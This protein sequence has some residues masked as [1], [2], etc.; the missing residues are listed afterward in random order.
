MEENARESLL[1]TKVLFIE[2]CAV[3]IICIIL[4]TRLSNGFKRNAK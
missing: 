1:Y 2:M 4:K 3:R